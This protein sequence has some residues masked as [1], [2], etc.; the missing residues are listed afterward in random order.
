MIRTSTETNE[1]KA[2]W[3]GGFTM[4]IVGLLADLAIYLD[5][6]IGLTA[7]RIFATFPKNSQEKLKKINATF[8]RHRN[9]YLGI[10]P[11]SREIKDSST[12]EIDLVRRCTNVKRVENQLDAQNLEAQNLEAQNLDAQNL[13]A[14]NLDALKLE[15]KKRE[16]QKVEDEL[17]LQ[18]GDVPGWVLVVLM[19]TGLVTALWT[20]AAPR[21]S[22]ILRNSLDSMN[23]IR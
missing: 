8:V 3:D 21:L 22:Q 10:G 14:Q 2:R 13:D 4:R 7:D 20:I 11:E 16:N 19:T 17:E 6:K 18:R 1:R 15:E 23:S 12:N 5:H 9:N